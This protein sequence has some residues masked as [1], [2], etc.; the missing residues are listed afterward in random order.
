MEN[1]TQIQQQ[2]K[3]AFL[4]IQKEKVIENFRFSNA[5]ERA[6]VIQN[7][8]SFLP[9]CIKSERVFWLKVRYALERISEAAEQG[10]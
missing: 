9:P 7:I 5:T 1:L 3:A 8:D 2:T 4:E 10:N 6:A